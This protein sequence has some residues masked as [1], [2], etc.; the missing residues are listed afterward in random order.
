ME[1]SKTENRRMERERHGSLGL[2]ER[3][4]EDRVT[5]GQSKRRRGQRTEDRGWVERLEG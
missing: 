1:E 3:G 5:G 2:G 4:T